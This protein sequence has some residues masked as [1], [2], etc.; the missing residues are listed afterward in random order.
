MTP[1]GHV[2]REIQLKA[3][4]PSNLVFGGADGKTVFVSQRQN[5]FIESFRTD[6]EGREHCLQEGRC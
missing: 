4:E 1:D 5:G 6:I 2:Q 3:E